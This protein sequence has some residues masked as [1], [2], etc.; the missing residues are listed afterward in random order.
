M[1]LDAL[2]AMDASGQIAM[3]TPERRAAFLAW[4][5]LMGVPV[6]EEHIVSLMETWLRWEQPDELR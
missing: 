3:L 4:C 2:E 6:D 5:D 1:T